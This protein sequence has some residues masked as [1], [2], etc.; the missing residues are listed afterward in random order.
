VNQYNISNI[1]A[2]PTSINKEG[3]NQLNEII[4][5]FPY[6]HTGQLLLCKG[7]HNID[8]IRFKTQLRKA[9][10]YAANRKVLFQLINKQQNKKTKKTIHINNELIKDEYHSFIDW[11]SII[12]TEKI[13]RSKNMKS[14]QIIDIFIKNQ[15]NLSRNNKQEFFK[16]T[17][18]GKKSIIENKDLITET[19]AKVYTKQQHFDKAISVYQKLSLKYPQKSSYFADQ[20]KLITKLKNK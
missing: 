20:I 16:S 11:L 18:I 12:K 8:S 2:D 3:I 14:N 10:S 13:D 15:P 6:F 19:L 1:I 7:L 17:D 4:K 9:A 5:E